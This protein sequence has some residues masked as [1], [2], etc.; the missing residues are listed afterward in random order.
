MF[1]QVYL[2]LFGVELTAN[3]DMLAMD[4]HMLCGQHRPRHLSRVSQDIGEGLQVVQ[5][6]VQV[7]IVGK[8]CWLRLQYPTTAVVPQDLQEV[9]IAQYVNEDEKES[10]VNDVSQSTYYHEEIG[11]V[12]LRTYQCLSCYAA[13]T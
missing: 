11:V 6:E 3:L 2:G 5:A 12:S 13:T 4:R 9:Y 7:I 8:F 10:M 1:S